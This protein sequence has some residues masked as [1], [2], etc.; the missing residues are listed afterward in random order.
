MIKR[1]DMAMKN[2]FSNLL[3]QLVVIISGFIMPKLF[4]TNFGSDVYGLI[5]SI[6]QFLSLI[7]L[8]E[9]GI[10]PII[11]ANLYKLMAKND[12]KKI[13]LLLKEADSFFRK[14]GYIFIVYVIVMCIFY[15]SIND[16]FDSVFT[17]TLIIIMSISTMF[18]YFLGIV[19]NLYLQADKKYYVTSYIQIVCY[20]V[21]IIVVVG[22]VYLGA[23]I[24]T[25]KV[26]NTLA[27]LIKPIFQSYYVRKK[28]NIKFKDVK[29]EY[30]INNKFDGLSQHIAYVIYSNTDV[31]VL[32]IFSN[33][34]TVA[35]YS[36][37]NLVATAVKNV[38]NAFSNSMDSIFGDMFARN[39]KDVLRRSFRMYEFVF[40]T[41][42]IIIYLST[43]VLIIPFI[44]IYTSGINDANYIQ[45]LFAILIILSGLICCVRVIYSTLVYSVG[46][47]KQTNVIC[48]IEAVTNFIVSVI[49]VF[50]CGIIGVAVGTFISTLI[51]LLY[52]M[53]YASKNILDRNINNC[54]KWIL[55]MILEVTCVLLLNNIKILKFIPKN[56]FE[57]VIYAIIVVLIVSIIVLLINIMFNFKIFKEVLEFLKNKFSKKS[58]NL[59]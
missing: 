19:Y 26:A 29:G 20:I 12:E 32:T 16:E 23:S 58:K 9:S 8:L 31:A 43:L 21:N 7:T 47:F 10:G 39:E 30:K 15:P 36:V 33:Y 45:P 42:A 49:M 22:L 5:A 50:K 53:Y 3:L 24:L 13:L 1:G 55:I 54:I 17:I 27:F 40:Y 2:I 56:Y 4:I 48:W 59:D 11:K 41:I 25:I 37:Y 46:H 6:T 35:I 57:W 34:A 14:I 44:R 51:R 38:V 28:L 18:E 52:F